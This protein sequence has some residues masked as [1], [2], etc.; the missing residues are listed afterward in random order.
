M[1]RRV[2]CAHP[3]CCRSVDAARRTGL[4][5]EHYLETIRA[6]EAVKPAPRWPVRVVMVPQP[7]TTF[8]DAY[9]FAPV[10]LPREPRHKEER[11]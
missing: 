4:C 7:S 2:L 11:V 10:S 3:G 9:S 1:P 8:N 6:V 5:V